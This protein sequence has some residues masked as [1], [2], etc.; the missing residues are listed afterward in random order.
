MEEVRLREKTGKELIEFRPG[1]SL[2]TVRVLTDLSREAKT[3]YKLVALKRHVRGKVE[4]FKTGA[5][6][7]CRRRDCITALEQPFRLSCTYTM[8]T[9][10]NR[11]TAGGKACLVVGSAGRVVV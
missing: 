11:H 1:W 5:G 2:W 3:T 8:V 10:A 9:P 4:L 7:S 6:P